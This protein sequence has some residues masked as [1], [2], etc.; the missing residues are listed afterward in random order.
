M[1]EEHIECKTDIKM[2]IHDAYTFREVDL[3]TDWAEVLL[4]SLPI[5]IF[6]IFALVWI[7]A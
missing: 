2:E 6:I 7:L 5:W 1:I 4:P 3:S